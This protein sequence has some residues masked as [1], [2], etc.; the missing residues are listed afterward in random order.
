[1]LLFLY[2]KNNPTNLI[3]AFG[4]YCKIVFGDPYAGGDP[5]RQWETEKRV[6]YYEAV[7]KW[8][9][10]EILLARVKLPIPNVGRYGNMLIIGKFVMMSVQ[11][12]KHLGNTLVEEKREKPKNL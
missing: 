11:K 9:L 7:G 4:L 2:V 12:G 5:I 10:V 6:W 8:L 3:D 1:V